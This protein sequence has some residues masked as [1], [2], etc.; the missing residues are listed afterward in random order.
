MQQLQPKHKC[1]T[2]SRET[3]ESEATFDGNVLSFLHCFCFLFSSVSL[4]FHFHTSLNTLLFVQ[5]TLHPFL[6]LISASLFLSLFPPPNHC[7]NHFSPSLHLFSRMAPV[8]VS[9]TT[10]L[11]AEMLLVPHQSTSCPVRCPRMCTAEQHNRSASAGCFWFAQGFFPFGELHRLGV[12]ELWLI[13]FSREVAVAQLLIF[14]LLTIS[15][16]E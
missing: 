4:V 9:S 1:H 15:H 7:F 11:Q 12:T 13:S 14:R 3:F 2:H 10:L 6:V 8:M 16:S 5:L